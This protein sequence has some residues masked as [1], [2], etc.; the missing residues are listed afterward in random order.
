LC[1][2]LSDTDS[3][4]GKTAH[5]REFFTKGTDGSEYR[6]PSRLYCVIS[7][8]ALPSAASYLCSNI[9]PE[10]SYRQTRPLLIES[11]SHGQDSNFQTRRNI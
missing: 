3:Y 9:D 10:T 5:V 2:V 4:T 6:N 1:A 11:T 8:I 7:V